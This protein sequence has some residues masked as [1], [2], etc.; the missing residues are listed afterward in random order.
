MLDKLNSRVEMTEDRISELEDRSKAFTQNRKKK[1]GGKKEKFQRTVGQ[2]QTNKSLESQK[3]KANG[4]EKLHEEIMAEEIPKLGKRHK[5][6]DS[7]SLA[8]T[9]SNMINPK[10]VLDWILVS[11]QIHMLNPNVKVL[12]G[13]PFGSD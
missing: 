4:T 12:G 2:K 10:S 1:T 6:T 13:G 8:N 11:L 3:E 9:K 5:S 7:S